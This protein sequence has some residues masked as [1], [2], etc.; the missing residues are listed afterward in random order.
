MV[1]LSR[2]LLPLYVVGK[3]DTVATVDAVKLRSSLLTRALDEVETVLF[4]RSGCSL[5]ESASGERESGRS[6]RYLEKG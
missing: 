5:L 3:E 6:G 2:P 1:S 4:D